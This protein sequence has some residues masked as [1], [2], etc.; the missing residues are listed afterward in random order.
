MALQP[1]E[2]L[3][4]AL[5]LTGN[6]APASCDLKK[7]K[8]V[9]CTNGVTATEDKQAGGMVLS[10]KDKDPVKIVAARDGRLLFSNGITSAMGSA[11]WVNFS[12]GVRARRS[13]GREIGFM[14][15]P[16]LF[17]EDVSE[18]SAACHRR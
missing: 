10:L 16:D 4:Y 2:V 17:C 18:T 7:D 13:T 9:V 6:P 8:T 12:T 5:V 3:I 11:G 1:L 14:I 15:A